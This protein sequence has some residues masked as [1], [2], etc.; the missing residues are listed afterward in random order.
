NYKGFKLMRIRQETP[1][2]LSESL[3]PYPCPLYT[4]WT[5]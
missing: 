3:E 4:S 1:D 5:E 2:L